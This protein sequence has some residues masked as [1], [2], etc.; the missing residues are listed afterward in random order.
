MKI[1][2]VGLGYLG[3]VHA[4]SMARLGH[5][6]VGVD[7]DADRV[8]ALAAGKAPFYEPGLDELLSEVT[9]TGRLTATTDMAA[10]AGA[11]VHF[12]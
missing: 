5:D 11:A 12:V 2:V 6:V 7:V 4:A 9:G 10:V 1:S 8:A 3:A